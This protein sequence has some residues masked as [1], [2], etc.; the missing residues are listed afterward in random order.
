M[1]ADVSVEVLTFG[2]L[3]RLQ[4]PQKVSLGDGH[5]LDAI[6]NPRDIFAGWMLKE[7]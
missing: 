7:V 4:K 2:E 3:N 6:G 1:G 5:E